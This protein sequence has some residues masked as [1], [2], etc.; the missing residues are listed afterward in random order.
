[1]EL[2]EKNSNYTNFI[3]GFNTLIKKNKIT[4]SNVDENILRKT[5][6][7]EQEFFYSSLISDPNGSIYIQDEEIKKTLESGSAWMK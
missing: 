4:F 7:F 1:M 3:E 5:Q 6:Q 2:S